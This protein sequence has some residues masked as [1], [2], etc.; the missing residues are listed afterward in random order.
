VRGGSDQKLGWKSKAWQNFRDGTHIERGS[1]KDGCRDYNS[2]A[3]TSEA[4]VS[5]FINYLSPVSPT[6]PIRT[7]SELSDSDGT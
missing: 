6:T 1:R 3:L 2:S 7:G 5:E 4:G